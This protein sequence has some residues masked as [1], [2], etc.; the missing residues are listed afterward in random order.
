MNLDFIDRIGSAGSRVVLT[1]ASAAVFTAACSRVDSA[2]TGSADSAIPTPTKPDIAPD[3]PI[4][5]TTIPR[6]CAFDSSARLVTTRGIGPAQLGMPIDDLKKL[7]AV[8]DSTL[9]EDEGQPAN[10]YAI[11]VGDGHASIL[12]FVEDVTKRIRHVS[13]LDSIFRTSA[14]IGV[15][16]TVGDVRRGH[17]K[18]CGGVWSAGIEV[19]PASLPDVMLGTTA[20]PPK[21]PEGGA[22]LGRDASAVP[23]SAHI[24]TITVSPGDRACR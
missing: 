1:L 15:G 18:L 24:T 10:A 11:S 13:T 4:S 17:G 5:T 21:M 20:Y 7:C 12:M 2:H 23:D 14:G 19:W 9:R 22:G 3:V 8:R 6:T 16:S